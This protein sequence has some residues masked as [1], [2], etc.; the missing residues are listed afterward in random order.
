MFYKTFTRQNSRRNIYT[1]FY[2]SHMRHLLEWFFSHLINRPND[3]AYLNGKAASI[4]TAPDGEILVNV[5]QQDRDYWKTIYAKR[6]T[7]DLVVSWIASTLKDIACEHIQ[8][9]WRD[10]T[11]T[12]DEKLGKELALKALWTRK[13]DEVVISAEMTHDVDVTVADIYFIYESVKHHKNL[14]RKYSKAL[15]DKW[16]S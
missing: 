5:D 10:C 7:D 3:R 4:K 9:R 16:R 6:P 1:G 15:I 14:D 2:S 11:M 8:K 12:D 13:N